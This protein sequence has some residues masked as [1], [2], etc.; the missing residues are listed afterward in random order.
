MLN[1]LRNFRVASSATLF[2][3]TFLWSGARG[4]D[5]PEGPFTDQPKLIR[6]RQEASVKAR[7][8]TAYFLMTVESES[9]QLAQAIRENQE[10]LADFTAALRRI[11]ISDAAIR[12]RNFLVTRATGPV[13]VTFARN[14]VITVEGLD[15]RPD[16][17]LARLMA[18]V[19]DLGARYGSDCITCIGSG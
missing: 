19:Q 9:G 3:L 1:T 15:R 17:E 12:I 10:Q 6:I 11:G 5:R 8:D 18:Q 2:S 4:S 13:G 14:L 16:E 7:P